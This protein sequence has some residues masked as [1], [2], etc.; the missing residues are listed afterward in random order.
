MLWVAGEAVHEQSNALVLPFM[1]S[2][3]AKPAHGN[4]AACCRVVCTHRANMTASVSSFVKAVT[5]K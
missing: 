5:G 2:L 4:L 3:L 1:R